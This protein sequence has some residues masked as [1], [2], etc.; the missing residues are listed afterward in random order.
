MASA[1]IL[2]VGSFTL[3]LGLYIVLSNLHMRAKKDNLVW[4]LC[5]PEVSY[6]VLEYCEVQKMTLKTC[7]YN[8]FL[9]LFYEMVWKKIPSSLVTTV[10]VS[11]LELLNPA[12]LVQL[13]KFYRGVGTTGQGA[14]TPNILTVGLAP[15]MLKLGRY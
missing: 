12:M 1:I 8:C 15:A 6:K 10:H 14:Q 5:P 7:A 3:A 4:A 9:I 11:L 13:L 2:W